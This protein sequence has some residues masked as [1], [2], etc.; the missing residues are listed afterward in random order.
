MKVYR[1]AT[2]GSIHLN[3]ATMTVQ[4]LMYYV[5]NTD[6]NINVDKYNDFSWL[7]LAYRSLKAKIDDDKPLLCLSASMLICRIPVVHG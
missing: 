4:H 2:D 5:Y 3:A 1:E 6:I 7:I